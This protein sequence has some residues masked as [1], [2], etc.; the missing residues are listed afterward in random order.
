MF[1]RLK[2]IQFRNMS[3]VKLSLSQIGQRKWALPCAEKSIWWY[4][5]VFV[6]EVVL[7]KK[8]FCK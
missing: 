8:G 1:V 4:L 3:N 6:V 2:K 7:K 5:I